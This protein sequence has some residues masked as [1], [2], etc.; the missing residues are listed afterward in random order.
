LRS[1]REYLATDAEPV[2]SSFS[3]MGMTILIAEDD[4]VSSIILRHYLRGFP[5]EVVAAKDGAEALE[6]IRTREDIRIVISDWMMPGM[7]GIDLC[8]HV[9]G[10][11]DRPYVYFILL[12]ARAFR[13]DRLAGLAA[14][15]D[16]FLTKPPDSAELN[17]RV[18]VALRLL[19]AQDELR[20]RSEQLEE[21]HTELQRQNERLADLATS[22][23]L[24]GLRN[25]RHFRA[26]LEMGVS[27]SR[28]QG[29]PL[30]LIMLDVDHFK[31][32]NDTFG[33]PAGDD[34]LSSLGRVLR[35]MVRDH[36]QVA[37]YGGEEFALLLPMADADG[38]RAIGERIRAAIASFDW[39]LRPITASLGIA[40][41]SAELDTP[42][43]L[44]DRADRA[45]YHSKAGGRDRVT[46]DR[47]LAPDPFAKDAGALILPAPGR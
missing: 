15:A 26:A 43:L 19:A 28:R 42:D 16:D 4:A 20:A 25:Y 33:H 3:R 44:L 11:V 23:G 45:L 22:D 30:S 40:T 35:E 24:T 14:G 1:R 21:L 12:T 13:K 5:E 8:R 2:A 9:R 17:A 27:F 29:T 36:D 7:D 32:Y 34:V 39:P 46:H 47:D 31:T 38:G 18:S 10:L 41:T 37:R 6:L